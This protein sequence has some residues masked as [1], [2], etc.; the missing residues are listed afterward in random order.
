LGIG[1]PSTY[2]SIVEKIKDRKYVEKKNIE[3]TKIKLN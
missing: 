1:R 3:G 2:C